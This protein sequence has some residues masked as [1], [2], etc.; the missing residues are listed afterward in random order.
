MK[1]LNGVSRRGIPG[2]KSRLIARQRGVTL[3]EM[4]IV[5]AILGVLAGAMIL[6]VRPLSPSSTEGDAD[7]AIA[8]VQ[9]AMIA[10]ALT[11]QSLPPPTSNGGWLDPATI[12][13]PAGMAIWYAADSRLATLSTIYTPDPHQRV[14]NVTG[15]DTRPLSWQSNF[16]ASPY[17]NFCATLQSALQFPQIE[18]GGVPAAFLIQ[19]SK[20]R[21]VPAPSPSLLPG[22]AQAQQLAMQGIRLQAVGMG[23]LFARLHC[24]S[25]LAGAGSAAKAVIAAQDMTQ[26]AQT[27]ERFRQLQVLQAQASQFSDRFA[28]ALR[29]L[30]LANQTADATSA[31]M[32]LALT[33]PGMLDATNPIAVAE[34]LGQMGG[35]IGFAQSVA[36]GIQSMFNINLQSDADG[37]QSANAAVVSAQNYVKQLKK[38]Q[39]GRQDQYQ[40]WVQGG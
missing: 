12:G 20:T 34:L 7:N 36:L 19:I 27:L 35:Y 11:H 30:T 32:Q 38:L 31:T 8:T 6:V 29:A 13:L 28:M 17:L 4:A 18:V 9:N 10:Y 1:K 3:L 22:S 14:P 5:I 23:E 2:G 16:P 21:N 37:I 40:T 33:P 26:V 25:Q 15:A 39:Q 24:P